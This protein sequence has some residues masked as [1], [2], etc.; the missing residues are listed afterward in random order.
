[1]PATI[2]IADRDEL[3]LHVHREMALNGPRCDLNHFDVSAVESFTAI[4]RNTAFNGDISQWDTR[5]MRTTMGMF[6]DCPFNGD[7]SN[8]N[9]SRLKIATSMFAHSE[10]NGD[11]S[12]WDVS[13]VESMVRMFEASWFRGDIS[14]WQVQ[15]ELI[16]TRHMFKGAVFAGDL[17]SW[18]LRQD[19]QLL[20]MVDPV[21]KG[22]L[23]QPEG[24]R[25]EA[26]HQM[27]GSFFHFVHYLKRSGL[28]STGIACM[29]DYSVAPVWVK[30]E[31]HA[32]V[33][34]QKK[35][36]QDLG[37]YG[38]DLFEMV[39]SNA[40]LK[41]SHDDIALDNTFALFT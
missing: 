31:D 32:W 39:V 35:I 11:I 5:S 10:F 17:S 1:M 20:E 13:K 16:D 40:K 19:C 6:V 3:R 18:T 38:R 14:Q 22:S 33:Q 12:R 21:F 2:V 24:K 8:W 28:N 25:E 36:G 26:Y 7:I 15:D 41:M 27:I 34:A 4:F 23:P 30:D 9:T 29:L 37:L